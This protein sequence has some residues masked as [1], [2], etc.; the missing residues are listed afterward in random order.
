VRDQG[1]GDVLTGIRRGTNKKP[2]GD[3]PM[4]KMLLMWLLAFALAAC[5][6]VPPKR[7]IAVDVVPKELVLPGYA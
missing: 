3:K 7:A 2:K 1:L 5:G 4:E 6:P